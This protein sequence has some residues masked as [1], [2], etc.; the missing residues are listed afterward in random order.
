L[1]HLKERKNT[2]VLTDILFQWTQMGWKVFP[3]HRWVAFAVLFW[4]TVSSVQAGCTSWEGLMVCRFLLAIPEAM[5]GPAVPLYLSFFYPRERLGLRVGLFLSGSALANAYGGALAYGISQAHGA[6][7]AW[8]ILF[9][10][11]GQIPPISILALSNISQVYQPSPS[12]E[13][14]GSGSPTAPAKPSSSP[15]ETAK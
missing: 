7:H 3:P 12:Q 11:E 4:G 1:F 14:P 15:T 8:R 9:L 13:W 2:D 10:V 5:Y 6:I